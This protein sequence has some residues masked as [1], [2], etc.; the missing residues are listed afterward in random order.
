MVRTGRQSFAQQTHVDAFNEH[1]EFP[2]QRLH[3][4]GLWAVMQTWE[5]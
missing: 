3:V 5:T 2:N 4:F 1:S